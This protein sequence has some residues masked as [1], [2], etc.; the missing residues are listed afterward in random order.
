MAGE[1]T[2][3]GIPGWEWG[4]ELAFVSLSVQCQEE[5]AGRV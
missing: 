5:A 4:N 1:L 3:C 2:W